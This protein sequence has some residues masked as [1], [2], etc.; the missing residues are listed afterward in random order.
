LGSSG[1][2]V[3]TG[4]GALPE[5][6]ATSAV[7]PGSAP[8]FT[9][10]R[11]IMSA[12]MILT[13]LVAACSRGEREPASDTGRL[14]TVAQVAEPV[15]QGEARAETTTVLVNRGTGGMAARTWWLLSP[16]SSAII[17]VEDA[18]GVEAEPVPNGF[19]FARESDGLVVQRDSVW[20]VAPSPDWRRLAW[21]R[22]Y[23][24]R[25]T[26]RDS[27]SR[28]DWM[29]FLERI[30]QPLLAALGTSRSTPAGRDSLI[31]ILRR[32]TFP[33]S[34]MSYAVA[35]GVAHHLD[36]EPGAREVPLRFDG[37]RVAWTADGS[38]L[39]IG[40]D[41]TGVQDESPPRR[42]VLVRPPSGDS[43]GF[44]ADARRFA[45]PRWVEG[46]VLDVSIDEPA[47]ELVAT[48]GRRFIVA[49]VPNPRAGEFDRKT[50][51]V[52]HHVRSR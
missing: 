30:P 36:L 33:S 17:V 26:E 47:R 41:P 1:E 3:T 21:G 46:P 13:A 10:Q 20:N 12:G 18:V 23:G 5:A 7:K 31:G 32:R 15:P 42:W 14:D 27:M 9:S 40:T 11:L 51:L 52:V 39:G 35:I 2:Q 22:A 16:D 37:W 50:I 4:E 44:A 25:P 6:G 48:R 49:L 28:A 29:E 38:T 45:T 24:P 43:I 19:L 34:G 8:S